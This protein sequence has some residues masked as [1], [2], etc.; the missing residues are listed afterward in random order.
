MANV[1][2]VDLK[3][4]L[5]AIEGEVREGWDD[6]LKN[7]A[8]ILGKR[9]AD[10]EAEFATFCEVSH[11]VGVGNGT[12]ALE[13]AMRALGIGPGDEAIV[14]TNTFIATALAVSRAGA[15]PVLVDVDEDYQLI[16]PKAVEA[17][18]TPKTK[19]IVPV[20]LFGQIAPMDPILAL[21]KKH[22]LKVLEDLAQSQGARQNGKR[23]G[24]FGVVGGTSFYPGKNIGAFGDG[25]AVVTD[26][27]EV[28]TK[29]RALR[30][31]GSDVKYHHPEQ[32][33]NS[34]LDPLQAVVLS[35]KLK[36]LEKWNGMRRAAAARYD[37]MLEGVDCILPKTMEGNEHVWH[38]YVVRVQ[39]R[40]GVLKKLHEAGIGAGIHY[41]VPVH[42]QGA[43]ADLGHSEGAFP[44]AE[45]VAKEILSLPL[46]P[47]ITEAQQQQVVDALKSAL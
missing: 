42:L 27:D 23:A 24:A 36:R 6:V 11:S 39:N 40:D 25:G 46:F 28:N 41:P 43:Y 13:I 10:F 17:A 21:A 18:I 31:Y 7:T 19:A 33:F 3:A 29:L 22:D 34:R 5:P 16:D 32:G 14:P 12:D 37:A 9:V 35:A 4:Q 45:K 15:T 20:H 30:N 47:E 44:V 1:P 8:F 38:L 26:S 2:L